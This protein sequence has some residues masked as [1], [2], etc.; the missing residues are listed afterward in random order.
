ML[1]QQ[2][3]SASKQHTRSQAAR[4]Q[5]ASRWPGIGLFAIPTAACSQVHMTTHRS[6]PHAAFGRCAP[7]ACVT[8]LCGADLAEQPEE[9]VQHPHDVHWRSLRP[10]S[11]P[12]ALSGC[13]CAMSPELLG[14]E[15]SL[16]AC[17]LPLALGLPVGWTCC[18][19]CSVQQHDTMPALQ[20]PH[21]C[22]HLPVFKK[23]TCSA[24]CSVHVVKLPAAQLSIA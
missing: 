13:V 24:P 19:A 22:T 11:A 9:P 4:K 17:F 7:A 23:A 21:L 5:A 18:S 10:R 15:A 8:M 1:L 3:L 14:P 20:N 6:Q 12:G 16:Q 2:L